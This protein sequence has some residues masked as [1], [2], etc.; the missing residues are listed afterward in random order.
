[1]TPNDP[2]TIGRLAWELLEARKA[3]PAGRV[4]AARGAWLNAYMQGLIAGA[5]TRPL[6]F[7]A[8]RRARK[9]GAR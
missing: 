1:V 4:R 2:M 3:K 6:L 8:A 5:A 9:R 7:K